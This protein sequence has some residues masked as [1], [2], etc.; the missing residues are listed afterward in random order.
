VFRR[1]GRE[2]KV[3]YFGIYERPGCRPVRRSTGTR[4][5]A[6]ADRLARELQGRLTYQRTFEG[7]CLYDAIAPDY[8]ETVA[9]GSQ[10]NWTANFRRW[11]PDL[12]GLYLSEITVDVVDRFVRRRRREKVVD[13]TISSALRYLSGLLNW[14]RR[15]RGPYGPGDDNVVR[16]W[17]RANARG[18]GRPALDP[19]KK[20]R[21]CLSDDEEQRL[22]EACRQELHRH[23]IGFAIE[24]GLRLHEQLLLQAWQIHRSGRAEIVIPAE[25]AK[26][27]EPRVV[28][29]SPRALGIL[30]A[31]GFDDEGIR[32]HSD[33]D[34]VFLRS[35]GQPYMHVHH[36][37]GRVKERAG[38]QCRWHDLRH[39]FA[40]RWLRRGGQLHTLQKMLGHSSITLTMRYTYVA[41]DD[42]HR[43]AARIWEPQVAAPPV[44]QRD[45]FVPQMGVPSDVSVHQVGVAESI[46]DTQLEL[47]GQLLTS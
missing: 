47:F 39:T 22:L 43:E 10:K 36:F 34:Y 33:D 4:V 45:V 32:Q 37:W 2:S 3:W 23:L 11:S 21:R 16:L 26:D 41:N 35:N 9:P 28:P 46:V 24:T 15:T 5:K 44:A 6:E 42:V 8:I 20:I 31:L 18:K 25:K 1:P 14:A 30:D 17:L 19:A 7:D 29:L 13:A 27:A 12:R 38:V 40:T